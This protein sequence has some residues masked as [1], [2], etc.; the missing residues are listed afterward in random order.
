MDANAQARG[1]L[2][3]V[4]DDQAGLVACA[5][6]GQG[7]GL[8]QATGLVLALVAVLQQGHAA[9]KGRFNVG[10]KLAGQ[11]LAVGDGIQTA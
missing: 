2:G 8:A 9:L 1:Q 5:K 7:L 10:Q 3:I 6:L 4:V 11:Q